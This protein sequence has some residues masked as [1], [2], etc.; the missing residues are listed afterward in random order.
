M[1]KNN[2]SNDLQLLKSSLLKVFNKINGDDFNNSIIEDIKILLNRIDKN[3]ESHKIDKIH[4]DKLILL[5][6]ICCDVLFRTSEYTRD[7]Q[8][9][10]TS[11]NVNKELLD[12]SLN[13]FKLDLPTQN[14]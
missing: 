6:K 4:F 9:R 5:Y 2:L 12:K 1:S 3:P 7:L 8:M 11:D 10:Y 13:D 14:N